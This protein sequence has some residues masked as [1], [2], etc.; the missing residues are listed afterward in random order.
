MGPASWVGCWTWLGGEP[1]PSPCVVKGWGSLSRGDDGGSRHRTKPTDCPRRA[2]R[3]V[4]HFQVIL[5]ARS[6]LTQPARAKAAAMGTLADTDPR[7]DQVARLK[8]AQCGDPHRDARQDLRDRAGK[9]A[10]LTD[11]GGDASRSAKARK[12]GS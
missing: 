1:D 6:K 4:L 10:R 8:T 2:Q 7:Q 9:I 5:I 12:R 3:L 11:P